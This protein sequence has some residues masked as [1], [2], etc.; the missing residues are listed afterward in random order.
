MQNKV[1]LENEIKK[2]TVLK[3]DDFKSWDNVYLYVDAIVTSGSSEEA[4]GSVFV[5]GNTSVGKSSLVGTL[6]EYCKDTT[7][8]PQPVLTGTDEHKDRL[9]TRVLDLVDNVQLQQKAYP[10]LK[11]RKGKVGIITE[12]DVTRDDQVPEPQ[13]RILENIKT[14]FVD[15]GGHSEYA[16]CSP[17]FIKEL[18]V[19]LI[20]FPLS[21]LGTESTLDDEYFPCIGTFLQLVS[22]NCEKPIFLLVATK[23]DQVDGSSISDRLSDVF[24]TAKEHLEEIAKK[25]EN[26]TPFIFDRIFRTSLDLNTQD[27]LKPVLDDIMSNLVAVFGHSDLMDVKLRPVPK[28]WRKTMDFWK[29]NHQ[30]VSLEVAAAEYQTLMEKD[31]YWMGGA[32]EEEITEDLEDWKS[33]V[34][35]LIEQERSFVPEVEDS[36]DS[37]PE[38]DSSSDNESFAEDE[39]NQDSVEE[40]MLSD[41]SMVRAVAEAENIEVPNN[42][43]CL[44]NLFNFFC[45]RKPHETKDSIEDEEEELPETISP[46]EITTHPSSSQVQE[47][48]SMEA[49]RGILTFFSSDNEVLWFRWGFKVIFNLFQNK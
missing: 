14:S 1:L 31:Q 29:E 46:A 22:E 43:N 45:K 32:R 48:G 23:A 17:I 9:K 42:S 7:K 5:L 33:A 18:G 27:M 47:H 30:Q 28:S 3:L 13:E 2:K 19:F 38:V 40:P 49:V 34:T 41:Q 35:R 37:E 12:A 21:R 24:T 36:T 26:R 15:F 11:V 25:S 6:R 8:I 20:C 44:E 16:S 10:K 39:L 4:K